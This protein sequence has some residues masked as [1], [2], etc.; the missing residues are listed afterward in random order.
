MGTIA[1]L[2]AQELLKI[3]PAQ[4]MGYVPSLVSLYLSSHLS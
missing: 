3:H 2:S 4:A 1:A